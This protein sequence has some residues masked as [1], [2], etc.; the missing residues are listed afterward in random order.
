MTQTTSRRA[1]L[2]NTITKYGA[3]VSEQAREAIVR[4]L[5]PIPDTL[6]A[7]SVESYFANRYK[8]K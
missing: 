2:D 4:A 1:I 3:E 5:S 6:Y 7:Y 8:D